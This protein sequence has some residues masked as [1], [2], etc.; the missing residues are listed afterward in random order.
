MRAGE[1]VL[2]LR[3]L[4]EPEL[5]RVAERRHG[6]EAIAHCLHRCEKL[7]YRRKIMRVLF[8]LRFTTRWVEAVTMRAT[9]GWGQFFYPRRDAPL[10]T[11]RGLNAHRGCSEESTQEVL[12]RRDQSHAALWRKQGLGGQGCSRV[13]RGSSRGRRAAWSS[14]ER[15]EN[16]VV[17]PVS[18]VVRLALESSLR[19]LRALHP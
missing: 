15:S 4:K 18:F 5:L 14:E 12:H 3:G 16:G 10:K 13:S 7:S 17:W 2:A 11:A 8:V 9:R 19:C 6:G 1:C